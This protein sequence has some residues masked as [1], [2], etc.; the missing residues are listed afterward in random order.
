MTSVTD[1]FA[2][3][4]FLTSEDLERVIDAAR[5]ELW[6]RE[7]E[8]YIKRDYDET[9]VSMWARTFART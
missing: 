7:S 6:D 2:T 1:I 9:R 4:A 5:F 8:E 3:L